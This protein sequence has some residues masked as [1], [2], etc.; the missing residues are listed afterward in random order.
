MG[1]SPIQTGVG[2]HLPPEMNWNA[3]KSSSQDS[4]IFFCSV[5][6]YTPP[7]AE[8]RRIPATSVTGI[9]FIQ[10]RIIRCEPGLLLLLLHQYHFFHIHEY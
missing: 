5:P 10:H 8:E 1:Y 9:L 4:W 3:Q 7:A 2:K 6:H